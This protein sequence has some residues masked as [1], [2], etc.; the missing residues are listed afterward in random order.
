MMNGVQEAKAQKIEKGKG[1][2]L[3]DAD[4]VTRF[5]FLVSNQDGCSDDSGD[6]DQHYY[7]NRWSQGQQTIDSNRRVMLKGVVAEVWIAEEHPHAC[8]RRLL[9]PQLNVACA[10]R[11][12]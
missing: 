9:N 4:H 2:S 10:K 6:A 12:D 7:L 5:S 1:G 11:K 3:F 8:M